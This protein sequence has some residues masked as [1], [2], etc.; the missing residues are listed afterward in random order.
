MLI[1]RDI[2][3]V[4]A[5]TRIPLPQPRPAFA[6]IDEKP[7]TTSDKAAPEQKKDSS[8]PESDKKSGNKETGSR[9]KPGQAQ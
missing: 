6:K 1:P 5:G 7:S 2:D 9:N 8:P 4:A 3:P